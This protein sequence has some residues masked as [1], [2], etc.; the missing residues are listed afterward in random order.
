MLFMLVGVPL[1]AAEAGSTGHHAG[2]GTAW[3]SLVA[4]GF[5]GYFAW[6]LMRCGDRFLASRAGT[7]PVDAPRPAGPIGS[8][9][10]TASAPEQ[11]VATLATA[12]GCAPARDA[13]LAV[14]RGPGAAAVAHLVMA[15]AM[16]VMLLG[17]L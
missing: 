16:A 3:A 6:H 7:A 8:P 2:T 12:C 14:L 5:A 15:A 13:R 4:I 9:A 10:L 17:M 11:T 1:T